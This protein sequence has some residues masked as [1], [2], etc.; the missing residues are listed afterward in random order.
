[1]PCLSIG[2]VFREGNR[3]E[4]ILMV[5]AGSGMAGGDVVLGVDDV[6]IRQIGDV[7]VI[8]VYWRYQA[9]TG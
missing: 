9:D 5:K 1:M 3:G 8:A 2:L 4:G 7:M 6:D